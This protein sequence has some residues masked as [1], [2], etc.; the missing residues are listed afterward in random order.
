M[1]R[2][3]KKIVKLNYTCPFCKDHI[4]T[5]SK[6]EIFYR[7]DWVD[8]CYNCFGLSISKTTASNFQQKNYSL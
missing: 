2:R 1:N 8:G 5:S 4:K 7:S 3:T 6:T